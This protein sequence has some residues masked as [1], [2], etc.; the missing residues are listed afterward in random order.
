LFGLG[1]GRVTLWAS[2]RSPAGQAP[3]ILISTCRGLPYDRSDY[4][5]LVKVTRPAR[6]SSL[7][8]KRTGPHGPVPISSP[9]SLL[10]NKIR[11]D[12]PMAFP[13]VPAGTQYRTGLRTRC[14]TLHQGW[15]SGLRR[16]PPVARH[17]SGPRYVS[18]HRH[19]HSTDRSLPWPDPWVTRPLAN[20]H[21]HCL[22]HPC[23]L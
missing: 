20:W 16:I 12:Q 2:R 4:S 6:A 23:R 22:C 14:C 17:V 18:R 13:P 19:C 10:A 11:D 8:P 21:G 3:T 7:M 1:F 9:R 15:S 5:I